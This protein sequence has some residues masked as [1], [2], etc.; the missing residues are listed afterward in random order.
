MKN[1][2]KRQLGH[3]WLG[4]DGC[5]HGATAHQRWALLRCLRPVAESS[6]RFSQGQGGRGFFTRRFGYL[7]YDPFIETGL[8][9]PKGNE[10]SCVAFFSPDV[11]ISNGQKIKQHRLKLRKSQKQLAAELDVSQKTLRGWE[12]DRWQ[13]SALLKERIGICAGH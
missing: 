10:T 8:K 3:D 5:Q 2:S 1:K 13:P 4:P 9:T 12:T 7:G 6:E 11:L